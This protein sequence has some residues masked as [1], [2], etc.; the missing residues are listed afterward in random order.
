[1]NYY[2]TRE[3]KELRDAAVERDGHE[4]KR[5]GSTKRLTAHHKIPRT[6]GGADHLDNL[7]TVCD[8]CHIK[9]HS[10]YNK[11]KREKYNPTD[12]ELREMGLGWTR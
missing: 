4:C 12:D 11:S 8:A 6:E 5:C 3:W 9:E 1:M 2:K 7:K 10:D